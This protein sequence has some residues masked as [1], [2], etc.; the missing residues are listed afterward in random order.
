MILSHSFIPGPV[1]SAIANP[2]LPVEIV[3]W[4]SWVLHY[5]V[6]LSINAF[7]PTPPSILARPEPYSYKQNPFMEK[8]AFLKPDY[9]TNARPM[10]EKSC[11][12]CNSMARCFVE[13]LVF[14]FSM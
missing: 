3:L 1:R 2:L 11:V 13:Q 10:E 8:L 5:C 12:K 14:R 6:H 9:T 7:I 4:G